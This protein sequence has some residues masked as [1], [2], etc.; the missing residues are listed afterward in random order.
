MLRQCTRCGRPFERRDF[1]KDESKHLETERRAAG[2]Q[3]VHFFDYLCP[4]CGT[5]DVFVDVVRQ[6]GETDAAYQA[7]KES[8]EAGVRRAQVEAIEVVVA[9]RGPQ[10]QNVRM[11]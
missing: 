3:G 6:E 5:E 2:L 10:D 1:V 8:L 4:R 7:R 11:A 9:E